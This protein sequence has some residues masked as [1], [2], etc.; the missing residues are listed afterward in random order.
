MVYSC[1][2][3][4]HNETALVFVLSRS[5]LL[6]LQEQC[7]TTA[8]HNANQNCLINFYAFMGKPLSHKDI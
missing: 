8:S 2:I 3:E 7:L 5:F 4:A 1:L 6:K